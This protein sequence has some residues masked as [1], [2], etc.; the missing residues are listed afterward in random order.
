MEF[1]STKGM[2]SENAP[3]GEVLVQYLDPFLG[4]FTTEITIGFYDN[5]QDY[6]NKDDAKGWCLWHNERQINVV[7]YAKLPDT[8][9]TKVE[10]LSQQEFIDKYGSLHPNLGCVGE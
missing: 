4:G 3:K 8:I 10:K 9:K 1:R 5:P 7:A 2:T 6:I